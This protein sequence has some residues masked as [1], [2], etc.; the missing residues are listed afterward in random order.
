MKGVSTPTPMK[1]LSIA[2]IPSL[3]TV[4]LAVGILKPLPG[5]STPYL[6]KFEFVFD[7]R[8]S[9]PIPE[10]VLYTVDVDVGLQPVIVAS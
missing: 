4:A 2:L 7:P 10:N 3:A 6:S 1:L 9:G 8:P 5:F